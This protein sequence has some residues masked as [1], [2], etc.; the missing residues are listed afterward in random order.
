MKMFDRTEILKKARENKDQITKGMLYHLERLEHS[1]IPQM[2]KKVRKYYEWD[3]R[4]E[5]PHT[6]KEKIPEDFW[7]RLHKFASEVETHDYYAAKELEMIQQVA[8]MFIEEKIK[9]ESKN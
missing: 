8:E 6:G 4:L 2:M 9:H 5:F 3:T 1:F 7:K